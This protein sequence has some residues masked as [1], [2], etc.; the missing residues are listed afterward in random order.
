M[1]A[2]GELHRLFLVNDWIKPHNNNNKS[3]IV[4]VFLS[5]HFAVTK[6]NQQL[7]KI[8]HEV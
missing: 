6:L 4:A 5:G 8:K 7:I 1:N 2:F 3:N